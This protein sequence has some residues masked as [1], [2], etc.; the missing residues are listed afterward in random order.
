MQDPPTLWQSLLLRRRGRNQ[1][2]QGNVFAV[3]VEFV[4]DSARLHRRR[5][6]RRGR[7]RGSNGVAANS[8]C[9]TKSKNEN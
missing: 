7:Q 5:Y 9:H 1:R 4:D 6:N 8:N 2:L 3:V